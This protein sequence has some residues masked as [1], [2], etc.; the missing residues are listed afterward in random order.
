MTRPAGHIFL[1]HLG[2]DYDTVI[3]QGLQ[4]LG[5]ARRL[6]TT[7][8]VF[9]KPNLTFPVYRKGVMT[10]PACVEAIVR[11]L[12]DY[13]SNII[14][15]EADSGGYNRFDIDLVFEK[16][17]LRT[18]EHKYG[19]QVVNLS[20]LPQV[21]L[22]FSYKGR[23][24]RVPFP[25]LLLE[26]QDLFITAPVPKIHMNTGVSM[27]IKNQ[28]GCIPEPTVR[29]KLHPFLEKVLYEINKR[30][31]PALSII[32]G[33]YGL[34]RTGPMLGD[35]LELNWLLMSED[36]YAADYACCQLMG[37]NPKRIYYLQYFE[38]EEG[39]LDV[40]HFR[41]SQDYHPFVRERFYLRRHWTDYPGLIAFRSPAIAHLAYHSR[42]SGVLHKLLYVFRE[43]FYNYTAPDETEK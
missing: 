39:Q 18:L 12:K 43:P 28:W 20:R 13:T 24:L 40:K 27:S 16:I 38:K 36:L 23:E 21:N 1:E 17:G 3:R 10:N 30:L 14:V 6:K 42:L 15:G 34:N 19:I 37:I 25:R 22:E 7:D 2:Q 32:D 9:I 5:I 31:R 8:T 26:Q 29:L 11:V 35:P 33:R 41:F 4:W